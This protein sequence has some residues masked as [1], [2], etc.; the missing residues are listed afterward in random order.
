MYQDGYLDSTEHRAA[1]ERLLTPSPK[2]ARLLRGFFAE[3]G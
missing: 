1:I 2:A 3:I